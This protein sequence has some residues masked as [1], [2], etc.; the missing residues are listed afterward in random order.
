MQQKKLKFQ[1]PLC[2]KELF[3]LSPEV[4]RNLLKIAHCLINR[5][6]KDRWSP[7]KIKVIL[8]CNNFKQAQMLILQGQTFTWTLWII[9]VFRQKAEIY[10]QLVQLNIYAVRCVKRYTKD[11]WI[12]AKIKAEMYVDLKHA[13]YWKQILPVHYKS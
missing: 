6:T 7:A 1:I 10:F 9:S 8:L 2:I 4:D 11:R 3:F 5:Y 13:F 12:Q